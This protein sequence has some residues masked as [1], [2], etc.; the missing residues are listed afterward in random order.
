MVSRFHDTASHVFGLVRRVRATAAGDCATAS[1][2]RDTAGRGFG[3]VGDLREAASRDFGTVS[4]VRD[5]VSRLCDPASRCFRRRGS[6]QE[7]AYLRYLAADSLA[8]TA[9]RVLLL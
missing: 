2:L 8:K 3:K 9:D 7:I 1:R 5:S 4:R 6:F